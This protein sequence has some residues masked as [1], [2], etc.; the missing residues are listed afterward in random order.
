MRDA[1]LQSML[2][3]GIKV[4][5]VHDPRMPLPADGGEIE[6][7][8]AGQDPWQL[9]Q[10][11]IERSDM[12]WLVAPESAG[13]LQRLTTLVQAAGKSLLSSPASAVALAASK[14]Q[15]Y[16]HL[17]A[18]GLN[19]VM[20]TRAPDFLAQHAWSD[21]HET[22][23]WVCKPDDGVSC[24]DTAL[25]D[26]QDHMQAWLAAG[27]LDTHVVQPYIAGQPSSLSML[28]KA[29]QAWL[30][31]CNTQLIAEPVAKPAINSELG[32]NFDLQSSSND[33][34]AFHYQGSVVNGMQ[35][36]WSAYANIAS[37]VAAAMPELF[38]YVGVD[39]IMDEAGKLQILEVNPRLTTSFAGIAH[40][41]GY[42]PACLLMDL[43]YNDDFT[44]PQGL[45]RN[46]I[47]IKLND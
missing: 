1:M 16:C 29:G 38:G 24:E 8:Q 45:Q 32:F 13:A 12:T 42:N 7:L 34:S 17:Q 15:T 5:V 14:Y 21:T 22:K 40:A 41:I 37:Q 4:T 33:A 10:Q 20:T 18:S 23:T 11:A 19:T 36:H 47:E 39:L 43:F 9:W 35:Q 3:M 26:N 30:L 27:R 2:E 46:R 6:Y 44:L 25:F 28:C 31:S